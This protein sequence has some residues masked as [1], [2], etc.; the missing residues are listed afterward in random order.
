MLSS[1]NNFDV[2]AIDFS[3]IEVETES[4]IG[5]LWCGFVLKLLFPTSTVLWTTGHSIH[6]LSLD[7]LGH[8]AAFL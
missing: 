4:F 6:L 5:D 2:W 8:V 1:A 7:C 3:N